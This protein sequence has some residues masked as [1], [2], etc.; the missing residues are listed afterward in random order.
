VDSGIEDS[1]VCQPESN[2]DKA[3]EG[4]QKEE[5]TTPTDVRV[6]WRNGAVGVRRVRQEKAIKSSPNESEKSRKGGF[7][8]VKTESYT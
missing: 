1:R 4:T 5:K 2:G 6:R 7:E 3:E 8:D